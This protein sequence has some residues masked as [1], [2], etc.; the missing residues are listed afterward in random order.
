MQLSIEAGTLTRPVP[1]EKYVDDSF[2]KAA[3]AAAIDI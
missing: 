2:V 1:Y 3:R